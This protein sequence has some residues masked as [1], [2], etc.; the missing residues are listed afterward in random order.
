MAVITAA[1]G[2]QQQ[3]EELQV[4]SIW[5]VIQRETNKPESDSMPAEDGKSVDAMLKPLSSASHKKAVSGGNIIGSLRL[6]L[7]SKE[8]VAI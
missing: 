5:D 2:A 6:R 3:G 8:G 7:A 4:A 1:A